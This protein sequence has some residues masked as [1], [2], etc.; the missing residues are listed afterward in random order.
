[1]V[2]DA[3]DVIM[4]G[5]VLFDAVDVIMNGEHVAVNKRWVCCSEQYVGML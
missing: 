1:M 4:N 2:C 3:M 5:A